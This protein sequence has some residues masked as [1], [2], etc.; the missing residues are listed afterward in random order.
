MPEIV[1]GGHRFREHIVRVK[2]ADG[3]HSIEVGFYKSARYPDGTP[4]TNV[5]AWNEFGTQG[6]FPT[7]ERPF[8]RQAIASARPK[9]HDHLKDSRVALDG[10]GV[11]VAGEVGLIV[12]NEIRDSI[13]RLDSPPNAPYTIEKKGSSNPLIDEGFMRDSVTSKVVVDNPSTSL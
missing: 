10:V 11:R 7:P 1:S 9:V 6:R 4:V 12:E 3:V 5:A 13:T 8:F 2:A